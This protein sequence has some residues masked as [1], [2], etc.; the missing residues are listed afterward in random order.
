MVV[1]VVHSTKLLTSHIIR[2]CNQ[3]DAQCAWHAA[4]HAL[5]SFVATRSNVVEHACAGK[6]LNGFVVLGAAYSLFCALGYY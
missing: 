6:E 4:V 3:G 5:S 2:F 1:A